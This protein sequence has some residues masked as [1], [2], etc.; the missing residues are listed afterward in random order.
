MS[1]R[2][3]LFQLEASFRS[4]PPLVSQLITFVKQGV[5]DLNFIRVFLPPAFAQ[6]IT[7]VK[8]GVRDFS[9]SRSAVEWGIQIPQDPEQTV[10]VWFDALNGQSKF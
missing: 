1:R 4:S 3:S 7:F 8:D 9:I 5:R 6:L 2:L 10:Y